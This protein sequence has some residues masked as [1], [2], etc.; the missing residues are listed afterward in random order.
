[1]IPLLHLCVCICSSMY[2]VIATEFKPRVIQLGQFQINGMQKAPF[3]VSPVPSRGHYWLQC[4]EL[5]SSLMCVYRYEAVEDRPHY[6]YVI[7]MLPAVRTKNWDK[8]SARR[9]K[10]S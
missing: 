8:S 6:Y 2:K 1:M 5:G 9:L 3:S 7:I 4:D 10:F